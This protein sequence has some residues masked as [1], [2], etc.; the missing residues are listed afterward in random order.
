MKKVFY[1]IFGILISLFLFF[2]SLGNTKVFADSAIEVSLEQQENDTLGSETKI[3]YIATIRNLNDLNAVSDI[4]FN[5]YLYKYDYVNSYSK[6]GTYTTTKVYDTVTGTNGKAHVDNTYYAVFTLTGVES[7]KDYTISTYV[8]LNTKASKIESNL[9]SH[10]IRDSGD[11]F[12]KGMDTSAVPALEKA[13]VV[14]RNDN[15]EV[16]DVFKVL[17]DHGINYIRVR[18]WNDPYYTQNGKKYGYGGGNCDLENAIAIGKRAN[19]YGMKL[20]VDFQ[21]SDF[22]ADPGKQKLPKAWAGYNESQVRTAI[23][24][25]TKQS[26]TEMKNNGIKVGMVQVGNE[27]NGFLCGSNNMTT[28]CS[29]FSSGASA[30]REVYPNSLVAVHFA[31][32]NKYATYTWY[33][34]ELN[35]NNVDYDVFGTSYYPYWHGTHSNLSTLLNEIATTYNKKVCV[36]ETAY[37]NTEEYTDSRSDSFGN[38]VFTRAQELSDDTNAYLPYDFSIAGQKKAL[39]DLFDLMSGV[40]NGLG[41]FYW[42]GTWI[43]TAY[44]Y[45]Y[46]SETFGTGWANKYAYYYD[47]KNYKL[48]N[49]GCVIE[50]E[51][52]FDEKGYPFDSLN[53]F[54]KGTFGN[55]DTDDSS[56]VVK[57]KASLGLSYGFGHTDKWSTNK[58]SM[59]HFYGEK[60]NSCNFTLE[61]NVSGIDGDYRFS[62]DIAGGNDSKNF[63]SDAVYAYAIING[64]EIKGSSIPLS[65]YDNWHTLS[66][67]FK[68]KRTDTVIVGISV[69]LPIV[70]SWGDIDNAE[71]AS[72]ASIYTNTLEN[73]GFESN[74]TSG[75]SISNGPATSIVKQMTGANNKTYGYNFYD[76]NEMNFN[77]YQDISGNQ[78]NVSFSIDV[79]G[80]NSQSFKIYAYI[81][82]NGKITNSS[83]LTSLQDWDNWIK[84]SVSGVSILSTDTVSVGVHITYTGTGGWGYLDNATLTIS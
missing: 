31:N 82:V 1:L 24:N 44:E 23:Y 2:V 67:S 11:T 43:K 73:A 72:L 56:W 52:F 80:M 68:A 45:S 58:S 75:W 50:N 78:G 55:F 13:G 84:V 26:L 39:S 34:S 41:V 47:S 18:I 57:D 15:G 10:T 16:E 77:I 70:K 20:L 61:K 37:A 9:V 53:V 8:A 22:W 36:F 76:A 19:K 66:V 21:Y 25:Y 65:G 74:S 51:A 64:V 60:A 79:S 81:N 29:Y 33:A 49:G 71:L 12:F 83:I 32:P 42:E 27:T 69:N 17:A 46:A 40:K 28:V 5:F 63:E 14:Y 3:R 7:F 30:V 48:E 4:T 54:K 35:K 38:T 6:N 62:I 59:F